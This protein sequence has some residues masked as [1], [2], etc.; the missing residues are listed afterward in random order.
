MD[1]RHLPRRIQGKERFQCRMQ[2]IESIQINRLFGRNGQ[3]GAGAIVVV[4]AM[5]DNN[6]DLSREYKE[7]LEEIQK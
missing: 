3:G 1:D 5:G 2:P 7:V 4:I 6:A